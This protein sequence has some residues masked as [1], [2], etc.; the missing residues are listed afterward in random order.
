MVINF[1]NDTKKN[2]NKQSF[3]FYYR[4]MKIET[5]RKLQMIPNNP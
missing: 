1:A 5:E 4:N 3:F 2:Q